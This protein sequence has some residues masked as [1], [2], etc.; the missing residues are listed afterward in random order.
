MLCAVSSGSAASG[1]TD[2]FDCFHRVRVDANH[3]SVA[4]VHQPLVASIIQLHIVCS[5]LERR[6]ARGSHV[7]AEDEVAI[8]AGVG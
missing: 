1:G 3:R 5:H 6:G 7:A 2:P 8:G 4:Q